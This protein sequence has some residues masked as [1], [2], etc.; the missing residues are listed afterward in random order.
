MCGC[1]IKKNSGAPGGLEQSRSCGEEEL[2]VV[3]GQVEDSTREYSVQYGS[4]PPA[5]TN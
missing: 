3:P 1:Y 4:Q 5:E 2:C